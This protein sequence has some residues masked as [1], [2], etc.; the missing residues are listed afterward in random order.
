MSVRELELI[1][2]SAGSL[3]VLLILFFLWRW[4]MP[5]RLKVEAYIGDWKTL[6]QFCKNKTTWRQ[7]LIDADQLLDKALKRRKYKGKRMGERLVSAQRTLTNNDG[8]WAAHN[9]SK[10]VVANPNSKLQESNVKAALFAYR[11]AL[12]D[13]GALPNGQSR[14]S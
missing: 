2:I 3:L 1:A 8:I 9:L 10:K 6:Q 14:N 7:A 13:I 11:Q 12:I 5:H 4:K